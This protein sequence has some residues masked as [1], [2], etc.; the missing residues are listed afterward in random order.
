M[1]PHVHASVVKGFPPTFS[2]LKLGWMFGCD[3]EVG[4][5]NAGLTQGTASMDSCPPCPLCSAFEVN[6]A[7]CTTENAWGME[8]ARL[9]LVILARIEGRGARSG[10]GK[11]VL[12]SLRVQFLRRE[13]LGKASVNL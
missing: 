10:P 12:G 6:E 4:A 7:L 3:V 8:A 11:L 9:A 1:E 5:A 13:R 2:F